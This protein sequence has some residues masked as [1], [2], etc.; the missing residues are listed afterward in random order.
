MRLIT[1]FNLLLIL[2]FA[3]SVTI[4]GYVSHDFLRRNARDV[5][6]QQARL[7]MSAAGGMR[8][9]TSKQVGP[10]VAGLQV[11]VNQVIT[12]MPAGKLG[13]ALPNLQSDAGKFPAQRVPAYSATEVF[14][15]LRQ[16]Y[17][18]YTYKEATL[19]PTNLR[20]RAAD[21]E[22]DVV[23]IFR[24]HP[25]QKEVIGERATPQGPALFL[26]RP[27]VAH[28]ECLVC[29]ST[30]DKAPAAMLASYGSD[31]GFGWNPEEVVSA[32]IVSV[33]TA[34]PVGIADR[35]FKT[36]LIS[37][38]GVFVLT[39]VLLDLGLVL[40]VVRPVGLLSRMADEISKGNMRV[41]QLPVKGKDEI[42]QLARSFNRM[43]L[44]LAKALKMIEA[45]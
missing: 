29:H 34:V 19:N 37:L 26:A 18:A 24:N 31:H 1:K 20:D 41:Q 33:P 42:A 38:G 2:V 12:S 44:S 7:M 5:V 36:L 10:L 45:G 8:T 30:P 9:Y 43:Y 22:T 3:V 17:P 15:Y 27:I 35:A 21:W 4:T 11:D 32:Q 16:D 40:I 23:E 25:E 6:L 13:A 28:Q 39:L 14:N